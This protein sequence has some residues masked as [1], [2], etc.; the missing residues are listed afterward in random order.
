MRRSA[1]VHAL[2]TDQLELLRPRRPS[3]LI[4]PFF[5]CAT[6]CAAV[7]LIDPISGGGLALLT[8]GIIALPIAMVRGFR[9]ARSRR[10]VLVRAPGRL[11]L[12]GEPLEVARIEL[13]VVKHW[14]LRAPRGYT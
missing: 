13:R 7:V 12:D 6:F 14:V 11:L 10:H 3:R 8:V 5:L 9:S 4:L 2:G 1:Y